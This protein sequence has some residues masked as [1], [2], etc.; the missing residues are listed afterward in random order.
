MV[1]H[2]REA[3]VEVRGCRRT[4]ELAQSRD[5]IPATEDD[6]A[7]EYSDLTISIKVV[8][9]CD[10]AIAHIHAHGSG[11]TETIVTEDQGAAQQF[12]ERIDAAGVY[13]NAST[14]F[15]DGFRYGFGAEL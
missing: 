6:W 11:H 9:S 14:R 4:I 10:E 1:R 8:E 2:F 3:G 7:T 13:H 15:A 5:V 12:L